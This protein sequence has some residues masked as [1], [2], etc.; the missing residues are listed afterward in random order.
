MRGTNLDGADLSQANVERFLWNRST[1]FTNVRGLDADPQAD[2]GE[3]AVTQPYVSALAA[4]NPRG[5]SSDLFQIDDE[6]IDETH[7][8]HA[9]EPS[10]A[11][12]EVEPALEPHDISARKPSVVIRYSRWQT[13]VT[14]A[15]LLVAV[16]AVVI[17]ALVIQRL[18]EAQET[19]TPLVQTPILPIEASTEDSPSVASVADDAAIA[20]L[21]HRLERTNQLVSTLRS[22]VYRHEQRAR[23]LEED[24]NAQR[25]ELAR[26]HLLDQT[27][28][29]ARQKLSN[30]QRRY[31]ALVT[32]KRRLQDTAAIMAVGVDRLRDENKE[33]KAFKE[34]RLGHAFDVR[35]LQDEADK[36][37]KNNLALEK[38]ITES[39]D[40]SQRLATALGR[41]QETMNHFLARIQGS[42]F[43]SYLTDADV[44]G[45][46]YDLVPGKPLLLGGDYLVTL[47]ANPAADDPRSLDTSLVVQRPPHASMPDITL[48]FL[49]PDQ[50]AL[51]SVS[52]S[53]PHIQSDQ[54]FVTAKSR[55]KFLFSRR[56]YV[57]S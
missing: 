27:E 9:P 32:E 29:S 23:S 55:S 21:E 53:F 57:S 16:P 13:V 15:A 47:D 2:T 50:R 52:Y 24:R 1:C 35:Q 5:P 25:I 28:S 45:S 26:Y 54:P 33:L 20:A 37:R 22:E 12:T 18:Q 10:H 43:Y 19:Q 56:R 11:S 14:A 42:Q 4:Q 8:Y 49:G 3:E 41:A 51:R 30:L 7:I 6:R 17:A 44:D 38:R 39:E 46:V 34:E 40:R 31:E 48:I 36:L